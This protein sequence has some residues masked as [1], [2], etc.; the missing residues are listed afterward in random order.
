MN[1]NKASGRE[2]KN[3]IKGLVTAAI[4]VGV[5]LLLY[6]ALSVFFQT[7]FF[8]RSTVNGVPASFKSADSVYHA[9]ME[10]AEDYTLSFVYSDGTV[11]STLT[12][13]EL[14]VRVNY[15][16]NQVQE[17][18]NSQNG[19]LWVAKLFSPAEYS[20]AKGNTYDADRVE[21]LA[22][23]LKFIQ[24]A[25]GVDGQDA[26]IDFDGKEYV[27]VPEVYGTKVSHESVVEAIIN[28]IENFDSE[29][30]IDN[31][32]C[33]SKPD[34]LSDDP[35]LAAALDTMNK[36]LNTEIHYDLGEG[37]TEEIPLD[38]K[39]T[40]FK[41][42]EDLSV[43]FDQDAIGDYVNEM[44]AKYNTFGKSKH[45][46]TT[47]GEE[48]NVACGSYG[49]QIAYQGEIDAIMADITA[50]QNVTRDFTYLY[51]ANSHGENDYGNN[52]VEVNLT[53]Q[54]VYVYKNGE[55]AVETK[56][57]SG[58]IS[59]GHGTHVGAYPI[60][61]KAKDATLRGQDYESHVKY[62]MPFNMGE[63]LH[64]ASW[65]SSFG[66]EIFTTG[67]SHGCVNLPTSAAKQVFENVEAGWP[68]LVFY[69]GNTQAEIYAANS[70][71]NHVISEIAA[72]ET[73]TMDSALSIVKA[74]ED[75]DNLSDEEKAQ[76]TNYDMLLNAEMQYQLLLIATG[77]KAPTPAVGNE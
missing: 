63:G 40:W 59:A 72:I 62:W 38:K 18:L 36:Y 14:G 28:A 21:A 37:Y 52:Y 11:E 8:I 9:I 57:V 22:S 71:V 23:S 67:G 15:D 35:K 45:L 1:D 76:V 75:Y 25:T 30:N 42:G 55:L 5:A 3:N 43:E 73:V 60:A 20:T 13:E 58:N 74:R 77:N 68:V 65:R 70:P 24:T 49:W 29:I 48:V 26:Y 4:V 56:C 66:G 32:D 33:Y 69:V 50:G 34:I 51:T 12:S 64:D 2:N 7:H 17:L 39:A 19:F 10:S 6:V 47:S 54:M 53:D 44:C 46:I 61:Y 27:I 31:G 16:S 41:T